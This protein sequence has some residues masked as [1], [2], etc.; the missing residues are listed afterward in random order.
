MPILAEEFAREIARH[1]TPFVG[2]QDK[3][4]YS[5]QEAAAYL[6][7]KVD[8][9]SRLIGSGELPSVRV[10]D[11]VCIDRLDLDRYIDRSKS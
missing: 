4:L 6:S 11:R 5:R 7:V 1:L 3:R 9:V 2:G 10:R 8:T